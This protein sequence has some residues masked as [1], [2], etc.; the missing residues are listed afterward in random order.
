MVMALPTAV[1]IPE[2]VTARCCFA[3]E[4]SLWSHPPNDHT[5][6]MYHRSSHSTSIDYI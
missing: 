5:Y 3:I 4:Q 2:D 1:H 6:H